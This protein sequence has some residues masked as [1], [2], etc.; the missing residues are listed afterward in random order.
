MHFNNVRH[1]NLVSRQHYLDYDLSHIPQ[2]VLRNAKSEAVGLDGN[3]YDKWTMHLGI[4][5][6]EN[7]LQAELECG[8]IVNERG[9]TTV[10]GFVFPSALSLF[11][12][13]LI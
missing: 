13:N 1:P 5:V 10:D 3:P 4:T 6:D 11:Y 12:E 9:E 2:Q 7:Q 8:R